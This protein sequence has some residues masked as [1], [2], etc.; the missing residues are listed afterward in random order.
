VIHETITSPCRLCQ[1]I[2]RFVG[3]RY[4]AADGAVPG[5]RP[6]EWG[7]TGCRRTSTQSRNSRIKAWCPAERIQKSQP[8]QESPKLVMRGRLAGLNGSWILAS[9]Y[10][11]RCAISLRGSPGAFFQLPAGASSRPFSCGRGI[12]SNGGLHGAPAAPR[13]RL[14]FHRRFKLPSRHMLSLPDKM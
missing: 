9:C 11:L 6:M 4:R 8:V 1:L 2:K 14:M 12:R 5:V 7:W 10:R 13:C 3:A